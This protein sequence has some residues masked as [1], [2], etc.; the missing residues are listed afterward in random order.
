MIDNIELFDKTLSSTRELS[1]DIIEDDEG[2]P[3]YFS[4]VTSKNLN[5]HDYHSQMLPK[6]Y[7]II[8]IE[9]TVAG[10]LKLSASAGIFQNENIRIVNSYDELINYLIYL[11]DIINRRDFSWFNSV[12]TEFINLNA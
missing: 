5:D 3:L 10:R 12:L 6:N 4:I 8:K 1:F 9:P 2:C 11:L 7:R